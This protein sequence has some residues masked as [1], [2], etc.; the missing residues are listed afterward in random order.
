MGIASHGLPLADCGEDPKRTIVP[1]SVDEAA[2]SWASFRNSRDLAIV[3]SM[4]LQG[5]RSQEVLE[6]NQDDLLLPEA[7]IRVRPLNFGVPLFVSLKGPLAESGEIQGQDSRLFPPTPG[8]PARAAGFPHSHRSGDGRPDPNFKQKKSGSLTAA[9][10]QFE[11]ANQSQKTTL[12]MSGFQDHSV[13]ENAARNPRLS[14]ILW[15][16]TPRSA[17]LPHP[18]KLSE[19]VGLRSS[20]EQRAKLL[21]ILVGARG[22]EPPASWSR[23]RK[24]RRIIGLAG[25]R[26]IARRCSLVL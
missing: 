23:T 21:K 1:L 9:E 19:W 10:N 17:A 8:N 5:L 25:L 12:S 15:L 2:R 24:G 11:R 13:L 4:L 3:G 7:Q 20:E 6:L 18:G 14:P 16:P 22:F 26:S